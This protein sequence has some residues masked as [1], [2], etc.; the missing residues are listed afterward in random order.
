MRRFGR[1]FLVYFQG[2]MMK[3]LNC[4]YYNKRVTTFNNGDVQSHDQE[5]SKLNSTINANSVAHT[6]TDDK[7]KK[8][9]FNKKNVATTKTK[10][11]LTKILLILVT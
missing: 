8:S 10:E 7:I 4:K 11:I 9:P 3:K 6:L 1:V 5:K 2:L